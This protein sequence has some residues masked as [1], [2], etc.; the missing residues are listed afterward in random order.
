MTI[1]NKPPRDEEW[2]VERSTHRS[3]WTAESTECPICQTSFEL[4]RRHFIVQLVEINKNKKYN[5][6]INK[7][8][9]FC[10]KNCAVD[11]LDSEGL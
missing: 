1:K 9:T 5:Q 6:L 4:R 2:H 11:W 3:V 8:L 10:E 7:N